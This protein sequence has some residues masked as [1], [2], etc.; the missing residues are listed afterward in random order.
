[1]PETATYI[2][3]LRSGRVDYIGHNMSTHLSTNDEADSLLRTNPELRA[4]SYYF[5]SNQ[6]FAMYVQDKPFD[7]IRVRRAMQMALDN[8]TIGCWT[9]RGT[10]A[11][12]RPRR[13]PP[14]DL[15]QSDWV[16][17]VA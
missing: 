15:G 3:A 16:Y 8:K 9:T 2:A 12:T 10:R 5:R 7:D 17:T 1:M 11:G 6:V 13:R 4:N 14:G